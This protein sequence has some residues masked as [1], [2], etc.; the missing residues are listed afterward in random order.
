MRGD[1]ISYA[2]PMPGPLADEPISPEVPV[3]RLATRADVH[4]IDALMKA[5]IRSI[6]PS[7]Y[8]ARQTASSVVYVGHVDTMLVDDGTYFVLEAGGGIVACGGWSRRD[9]LFS[10]EADQEGRIRSLDPATEAAHVRAMFVR[11]D[12]TRR[13]L[14][15][16]ILD[17]CR[18]AARAE[19]FRDLDLMATLPGARLYEHY[20]FRPGEATSITLPDG[21]VVEC[22]PMGMPIDG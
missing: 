20:G 21:V 11:G 18:D 7:F 1:A 9:K 12:W 19:G 22:I 10:G 16:R 4:A 6:F 15:T 2:P 8:D 13:G 5:S 3:L 17:A 14:G